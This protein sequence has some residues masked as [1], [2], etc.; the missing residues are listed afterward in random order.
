MNFRTLMT[1]TLLAAFTCTALAADPAAALPTIKADKPMDTPAWALK[2]RELLDLNGQIAKE[3]DRAFLLPNG[4]TKLTFIHGGGTQAPDD[5]FECIYKM[6]LVYALGGGDETWNVYWKAFK[7]SLTQLTQQKLFANEMA[8]YLDWHHN[9]EHYE[10]FW[11]G[12]LCAANDPEYRRLALKYASLYDGTDPN[13]PNYDPNHKVIRSMNSGGAGPIIHARYEDWNEELSSDPN[14]LTGSKK[15]AGAKEF[16]SHWLECGH[17]GPANLNIT[18][19][20]TVAFLLTGD[21]NYK[22]RTMDYLNAWR[23]RAKA[24]GGMAPSI[25][26]LDGKVPAEWW[27]GVMGWDFQQF[28]GL[29]QVSG[30]TRAAWGN[31]LLM[32][33]DISYFDELRAEADEVWN[34]RF[35]SKHVKDSNVS[36]LPRYRGKDGWHGELFNGVQGGQN[37][38]GIYASITANLYLATMKKEDLDRVLDRPVIGMAGHAFYHE[39]GSEL[40]W[41]RYLQGQDPSYPDKALDQMIKLAKTDGSHGLPSLK[42]LPDASDANA[43]TGNSPQVG[44][45]GAL[46]NLMT[47]GIMPLWHGQLL[48]ARLFYYDPVRKRPGI[49]EDCAALVEKLADDSATV[50]LVNTSKDKART[51]VVQGGAYGEHQFL[52]ATPEGGQATAVNGPR[53]SVELAAGAGVRLTIQMK[54]YANTPTLKQP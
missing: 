16:W 23:D 41:I 19:F 18:S 54:R 3:F 9:G 40:L 37:C 42:K 13:V 26:N 49:A 14:D 46:V 31:A 53:F 10:G 47:G 11:L 20:G 36:D 27:G 29:F 33:G 1:L 24:N 21:P 48:H 38:T 50:V 7:G 30:G 28:G 5:F 15:Q 43:M 51:V 25:V 8:K 32:T 34:N 6:P 39:G 52:S 2:E 45:A 4:Y 12:A 44:W 22:Q 17:D 35:P